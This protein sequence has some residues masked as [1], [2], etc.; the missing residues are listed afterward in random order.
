MSGRPLQRLSIL[1]QILIAAALALVALGLWQLNAGST[2]FFHSSEVAFTDASA[3][4]LLI[5]PASCPSEPPHYAGDTGLP[6][7]GG[8]GGGGGGGGSGVCPS[9]QTWNGSQCVGQCPA[10]Q[11]WDGSQCL[12]T[13]PAP[14]QVINGVC[15]CPAGQTWNGTS[16]VASQCVSEYIC[17]GNALYFRGANCGLTLQESCSVSCSAS[18]SPPTVDISVN[19]A[20]VRVDERTTV[21][22][23]VANVNNCFVTGGQDSWTSSGAGTFSNQSSPVP[24]RT[25]YRLSCA[26]RNG[27]NPTDVATVSI[28]PVFE[29]N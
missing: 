24:S 27:S 19:P 10:G 11:I 3:S 4:S 1:A 9:G 20:L 28:L 29:E 21:S 12:N 7:C 14:R 26:A 2:P 8:G 13:C 18:C 16:C 25:E 6:N 15:R 17:Q 22:W 23:T 5:V